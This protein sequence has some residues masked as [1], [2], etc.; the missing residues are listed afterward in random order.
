MTN[1][2]AIADDETVFNTPYLLEPLILSSYL[3]QPPTVNNQI[4][5]IRH[6]EFMTDAQV[7]SANKATGVLV[8]AQDEG[9]VGSQR[10][11]AW[12]P[13]KK[14]IPIYQAELDSDPALVQNED[15]FK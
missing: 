13:T 10:T 3:K 12:K 5:L 7:S 1:V 14:Y 15:Y 8:P 9:V 4:A 11:N 6:R 2:D